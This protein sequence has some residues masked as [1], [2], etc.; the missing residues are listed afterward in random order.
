MPIRFQFFI[1]YGILGAV[2]P[3]LP[4]FLTGEKGFTDQQVSFAFSLGSAG[5]ILSPAVVTLLADTRFD[6]RRILA[7]AYLGSACTLT[8]LYFSQGVASTLLLYAVFC[9]FFTPTISLLDGFYF[10]VSRARIKDELPTT[11]YNRVR[12]W[13]TIGFMVPSIVFLVL[14]HFIEVGGALIFSA[15]AYCAV[16]LVAAFALPAPPPH[17]DEE[18]RSLPSFDALKALFA[19]G[20]R[21]FSIGLALALMAMPIYY[22][23]FPIYLRDYAEVPKAWI[24]V[25]INV[26]VFLEIFFILHLDKI[27]ARLRLKGIL[28]IGMF[29]MAARLV[30]ISLFPSVAAGLLTQILHGMEILG[31]IVVP[32]MYLDRLAGDRFRNSMQGVYAMTLVGGGRIAGTL[33][34][35]YI[36]ERAGILNAFYWGAFLA[37]AGAMIVLIKFK[38][39]PSKSPE[40]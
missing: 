37:A 8:F 18:K 27:R 10:A 20:T 36:A 23:Y 2:M 15:V 40:F 11:P 14:L 25:I 31:A 28:V 33:I 6:T 38:P 9:I 5:L 1:S 32:V 34:G 12:L 22:M 30:I 21:W 17:T 7:V 24:G 3:L 35:G 4:V 26:G 29:A 16:S 39:V 19:P 13:G